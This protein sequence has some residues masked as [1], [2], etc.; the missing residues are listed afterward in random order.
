MVHTRQHLEGEVATKRHSL[1]GISNVAAGGHSCMLR[2]KSFQEHLDVVLPRI[3]A[4]AF[5][6]GSHQ[7]PVKTVTVT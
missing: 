5:K 4:E 3:M 7:C 6:Y 1:A 2:R